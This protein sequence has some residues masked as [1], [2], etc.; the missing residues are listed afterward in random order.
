[1]P[2]ANAPSALRKLFS[3]SV[4]DTGR[5]LNSSATQVTETSPADS[6]TAA[7]SM[8]LIVSLAPLSPPVSPGLSEAPH[9]RA[10]YFETD[11]A[12]RALQGT[13]AIPYTAA[14]FPDLVASVWPFLGC[15]LLR[16]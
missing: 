11:P 7:T 10:D 4:K 1:M 2:Y 8:S 9:S 12:T 14:L 6:P 16:A 5:S 13:P 3:G 15:H